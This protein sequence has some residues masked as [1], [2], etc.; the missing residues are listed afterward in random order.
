MSLFHR[1][2]VATDLS[3]H[4]TRVTDAAI[5]LARDEGTTLL[6][7]HVFEIPVWE[8][9]PGALVNI[10]LVDRLEGEAKRAL[11]KEHE[12]VSAA[13]PG[14]RSILRRGLA[15]DQILSVLSDENADLL[16]VGALRGR[17]LAHVLLGSVAERLVRLAP[18]PV[19]TM[20]PVG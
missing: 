3:A 15:A 14:S 19:L 6:L 7:V 4:S 1:L 5:A 2:V 11:A 8:Y 20:R 10:D 17:R 9:Q 13:F 12:R 16:I 18:I